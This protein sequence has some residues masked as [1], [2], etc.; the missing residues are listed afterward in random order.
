MA[1][2]QYN[3]TLLTLCH[4]TFQ[5]AGVYGLSYVS[6]FKRQLQTRQLT[7]SIMSSWM[8]Y[9][10]NTR[11]VSLSAQSNVRQLLKLTISRAWDK[12]NLMLGSVHIYLKKEKKCWR[13]WASTTLTTSLMKCVCVML[14]K[15][16][17]HFFFSF[18]CAK[19]GKHLHFSLPIEYLHNI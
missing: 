12:E 16:P 8:Q 15:S 17:P 10:N 1:P 7:L 18:Y 5:C 11:Y 6:L 4:I 9:H 3:H 14:I 2:H 19:F 13:L